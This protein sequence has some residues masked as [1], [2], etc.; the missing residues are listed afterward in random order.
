M[1]RFGAR[2]NFFERDVVDRGLKKGEIRQDYSLIVRLR[3][4][5]LRL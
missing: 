2:S 4:K 3:E 1:K 5:I